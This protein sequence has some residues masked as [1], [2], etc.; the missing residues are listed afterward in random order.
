MTR[1]RAIVADDE[2][3]ARRRVVRLLEEHGVEVVAQ[4][5]N[6]A[7]VVAAL[8]LHPDVVVL[9]ISMPGET[10]LELRARLPEALPVIFV[11]A[12]DEHAVRAFE[13][14]AIDYV[15]KPVTGARLGK[16]LA[17]VR[18]APASTERIAIE[19][20]TGVVLVDPA[21]I[22]SA[23]F[24]GT[25]VTIATAL[26]SYIT[27]DSLAELEAKLP[28]RFARVDRRHL[29]NLDEIAR[30]EPEADGGAQAITRS[31]TRVP[32]SRA[33]A[34]ELRRRYGW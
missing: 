10:G 4:C 14:G 9:D 28:A 11:T 26:G 24:D 15:M 7:E 22:V 2:L 5:A 23:A 13:L 21:A 20:R 16:A 19:T 29:V 1:L 3:I 25:L 17:R 31:G 12:H 33:A 6:A 8:H 27:T 34:R 30:L 32:V 18:G